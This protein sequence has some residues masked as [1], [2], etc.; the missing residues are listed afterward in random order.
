VTRLLGI[1]SHC[2][3]NNTAESKEHMTDPTTIDDLFKRPQPATA[4]VGEYEREQRRIRDN[5]QLLKQQ[6]REREASAT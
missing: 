4:T 3:Q 5:Y 1:Q 2:N 6:R